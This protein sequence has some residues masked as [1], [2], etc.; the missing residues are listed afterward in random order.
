[1]TEIYILAILINVMLAA[2]EIISTINSHKR[3]WYKLAYA[4]M[5]VA[6]F[7]VGIALTLATRFI[8]Q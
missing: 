4:S 3:G 7:N 5:A 2:I 8:I 1:M 6:G